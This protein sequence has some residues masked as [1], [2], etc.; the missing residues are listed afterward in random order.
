MISIEITEIVPA[1][2]TALIILSIV[3]IFFIPKELLASGYGNLTGS[4]LIMPRDVN[5]E[6]M[7]IVRDANGDVAGYN[8]EIRT[9]LAYINTESLKEDTIN[10]V[11]IVHF[12]G[13]SA[14]GSPFTMTKQEMTSGAGGVRWNL[15]FN[16]QTSE[17]PYKTEQS[18]FSGEV[19][20]KDGLVMKSGEGGDFLVKAEKYDVTGIFTKSC[21]IGFR[22][23]C[24][25][26]TKALYM[27]EKEDC[28]ASGGQYL[29]YE[30]SNACSGIVEIEMNERPDCDARKNTMSIAVKKGTE[31]PVQ[32]EVSI[33][34]WK[35]TQ[36]VEGET[37]YR[38]LTGLC[39]LDRL[40]GL[41]LYG[42]P[43]FG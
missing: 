42:F 36:C 3:I 4:F 2:L 28:I 32:E 6:V 37:D 34:F 19:S 18:P 5:T 40:S 26:D 15:S 27:D 25:N 23:Q 1:M 17:P 13:G 24:G 14:R 41:Y 21:E 16:V 8:L 35:D 20:E 9:T 38:R 43:L 30:N 7:D 33:S 39:E 29:C 11:P 10:A 22:I 12:K 31:G